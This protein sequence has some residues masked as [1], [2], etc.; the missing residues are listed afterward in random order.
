MFGFLFIFLL[1]PQII[2]S[3]N[4]KQCY[5]K[6]DT[7]QTPILIPGAEYCTST[8]IDG[9]FYGGTTKSS[10]I[11]DIND[12]H[13]C[14]ISLC[15]YPEICDANYLPTWTLVLILVAI[16]CLPLVFFGGFFIVLKCRERSNSQQTAETAESTAESFHSAAENI[17]ESIAENIAESNAESISQN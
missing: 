2:F 3:T 4:E 15:N 6:N 9:Q 16:F 1:G 12:V 5:F 14:P 11:C 8:C 17:A 10:L 7:L 13:C